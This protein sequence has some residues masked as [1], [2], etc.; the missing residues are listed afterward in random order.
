[1]FRFYSKDEQV[2]EGSGSKVSELT[3]AYDGEVTRVLDGQIGNV[4]QGRDEEQNIFRPHTFLLARSFVKVPLS[5]WLRGADKKVFVESTER[6]GS[7]DCVKLR[8]ETWKDNVLRTIRFLWIAPTRNYL[9]IRHVAYLTHYS[10]T[11]PITVGES[12]EFK[13]LAPGIWLPYRISLTINDEWLAREGRTVTSNTETWTIRTAELDP[14]HDVSFFRDVTFPKGT[15]VYEIVDGK[16]V[17]DR[18]EGRERDDRSKS[19][20]TRLLLWIGGALALVC[21]CLVVA[22]KVRRRR[23][24]P[25]EATA[26]K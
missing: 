16:I 12:T 7:L 11:I 2:I 23:I 5:Q 18:I 22:F 6:I 19:G 9:P 13:E 1:M 4:H 3:R 24:A 14:K 15:A 21:L 26:I 17:S 20:I 25:S 10:R 8:C